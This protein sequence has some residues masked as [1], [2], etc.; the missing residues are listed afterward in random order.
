MWMKQIVL[1]QHKTASC[2]PGLPQRPARPYTVADPAA[3]KASIGGRLVVA[4]GVE[5]LAL[6][7][8]TIRSH[9]GAAYSNV[10]SV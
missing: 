1:N 2:R 9:H 5:E 8:V 3:E 7:Y 4:D 10:G 6:G